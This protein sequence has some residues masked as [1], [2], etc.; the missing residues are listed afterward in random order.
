[1]GPELLLLLLPFLLAVLRDVPAPAGMAL[2]WPGGTWGHSWPCLE[3]D[4]PMTQQFH[5]TEKPCAHRLLIPP[6]PLSSA[7]SKG[8]SHTRAGCAQPLS[9]PLCL[10]QSAPS[11]IIREDLWPGP[12]LCPAEGEFQVLTRTQTA[13]LPRSGN[14]LLIPWTLGQIQSAKSCSE[15]VFTV[16]STS[17]PHPHLCSQER[18]FYSF[19]KQKNP[20]FSFPV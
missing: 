16:V 9:T 6:G 17:A 15:H 12:S 19:K 1:M 8:Q 10:A 20:F 13:E 2:P 14:S 11:W 7:R 4:F 3:L 18:L 5:E